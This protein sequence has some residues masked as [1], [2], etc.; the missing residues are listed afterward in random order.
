MVLT[1]RSV[2]ESP[3]R[4]GCWSTTRSVVSVRSEMT[5]VGVTAK[6]DSSPVRLTTYTGMFLLNF[7]EPVLPS[8]PKTL[9]LSNLQLEVSM[10]V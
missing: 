9:E 4:V 10:S 3:S 6:S 1:A 5:C 8:P 7:G 2:E